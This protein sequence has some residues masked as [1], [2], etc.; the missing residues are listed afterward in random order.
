MD[1]TAKHATAK[2]AVW[3]DMKDCPIPENYVS[4]LIRS[5][6]EGKFEE[7]GYFG[8]V[9]ITAYG[10]QTQISDYKLQG[11][12]TA[13]ISVVHTR[14]ESRHYHMY[15]DI[16]E[17][18][19]QNPPP[20][21]MMIISDEVQGVFDWD[22]LRLQQRT[23]YNLFLAYSEG[24]QAGVILH[25]SAEWSWRELLYGSKSRRFGFHYPKL[26]C[27]SCNFDCNF[28]C[29]TLTKFK[30]HLSSFKHIRQEDV[31]PTYEQVACVTKDWG[32][33]YKAT[34]EYATAKIQVW[35]DMTTCPIPEGYDPR[36][37][38]PSI[39]AAFKELGYSGPVSITA[40]ADHN[41]TPLQALSSTGIDVV[42]VVPRFT[43]I[44]TDVFNWHHNNPPQAAAIMMVIS[45]QVDWIKH[46][47]VGLLQANN[48]ILFLAYS[49]RPSKKSFLLTSGEWLWEDL[50]AVSEKR[51]QFL[52]KC[53]LLQK[54][55][56]E[57]ESGGEPTATF[58]CKLCSF[59]TKS[60]DNY[61]THLSTDEEHA[62]E[63][64]RIPAYYN[65]KIKDNRRSRVAHYNRNHLR[66][67]KEY[68]KSERKRMKKAIRTGFGL[69]HNQLRR[70]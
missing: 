53:S 37:V 44:S 62:K 39:E 10:D 29:R 7:R 51:A 70:R 56:S 25:T 15:R 54:C 67:V 30:K 68:R 64:K 24:C 45:D 8:P 34:P 16:V 20:A 55:S 57:S 32:R 5:S 35:W 48:Y 65:S 18:R 59:D 6:I 1:A 26:Y 66:E 43:Y 33:N 50:L 69:L 27:Y 23:L 41:H 19:G 21:T 3:W 13:G 60:I 36:R 2:I 40:F 42:H 38:R 17:W 28:N 11:L 9:T 31:N 22:L 46:C 47:L 49:F 61:R 52:Q 12:W 4:G 63:E 14:S 58:Y